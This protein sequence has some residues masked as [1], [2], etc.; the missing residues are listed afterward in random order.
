[1][2]RLAE[3]GLESERGFGCLP[4]L[5]T[6]GDRW[7]N[8]LCAVADRINVGQQRPTQGELRVQPHRFSEIF[9]CA[10]SA[11]GSEVSFQRVRKP[12]QVSIVGFWIVRWFGGNDLLFPTSKF[13]SQLI[14]DG[15]CYLTFDGKDVGQFTIKCIG[16][17]M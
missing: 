8:S 6:E 15:F 3:I 7:L 4:R 14:G 5:F 1:M 16:P 13:R 17:K 9:L 11:G 2:Q 10:K 12:T